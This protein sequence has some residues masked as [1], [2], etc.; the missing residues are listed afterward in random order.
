[1]ASVW[2]WVSELPEQDV[3]KALI[4]NCPLHLSDDFKLRLSPLG[5]VWAM[6]QLRRW[7]AVCLDAPWLP[8]WPKTRLNTIAFSGGHWSSAELCYHSQAHSAQLLCIP[9]VCALANEGAALLGSLSL[10]SASSPPFIEQL[11]FLL[12]SDRESINKFLA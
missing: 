1:M 9:W 2:P 8:L 11:F 12:S 3:F 4:G 10:L 6:L 5:P 7:L